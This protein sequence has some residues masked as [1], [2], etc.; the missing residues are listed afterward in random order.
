MQVFGRAVA[1]L[2][3]EAMARFDVVI[4]GG[5]IF[6]G[7][8]NP[9]YLSDIGIK[10]GVIAEIG[11]LPDSD[12][13]KVLD[14]GGMHV[15]PGFIDLHTHYDGQIFWDP[16]CSISGWHGTTSV[17]IGNCGF[18]LAPVMS[19]L[20]DRSML[21]LTRNEAIPLASMRAGIPWDWET[22]PEYL[23]SVDR[24]PKSVNVLPYVGLTPLL[25]WVMGMDRAK[26]G[27]LPT[28]AEHQ[29]MRRLLHEAMDAGACGWSVQRMSTE[30]NFQRDFDGTPLPT[31]VMHDET[32]L[33]L[34][35]V[36]GE[37]NAGFMQMTL[38]RS[39]TD[40]TADRAHTEQ[41]A[42][43]SRRPVIWNAVS[44]FA[45]APVHR[46]VIGWLTS[47]RERGLR[48]YGQAATTEAPLF[49]TFEDWNLWDDSPAWREA[50][51]GTTEE[52]LAKL[53]DPVRREAMRTTPT[54]AGSSGP[55]EDIVLLRTSVAEHKQ[56]ENLKISDICVLA[57]KDAI[58]A[59][60]DIAVADGLKALF[61]TEPFNG[62]RAYQ[63][64]V[65]EFEYGIAGVSDGGAHTK[66]LT[67]GRYPTEYLIKWV[68]DLAWISLEDAHWRLSAYPAFCAGFTN[69]G[70]IKVG[71]PA[72]II[73]YDFA[74]L[75]VQPPEIV[76][77]FPADEWR[78]V[79][80]AKGY[81]Y[82]LVNG[83]VTIE[84]DKET[85]VSSGRLLRHGV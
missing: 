42:A 26:A 64:E 28:D 71:A 20:R 1:E 77:D 47:C 73:V 63:R 8:R 59:I 38:S 7:A 40:P 79:Q 82:V 69:R 13:T 56:Y 37:R 25:I 76:F 57:G 46:D 49:F 85:G 34:A 21:A 43:I 18:G 75:E 78:R 41:L 36:L 10:D 52:R 23:E 70:V 66:F 55:I 44:A 74:N 81:R 68:R 3:G 61:Y 16:Y 67:A 72:D 29:E 58:D 62:P 33:Q 51:L 14:A 31:D 48:V 11:L 84:D 12:A 65:V 6:D 19:E 5:M 50:T 30:I 35:E 4:K 17:V 24:T 9:R 2:G 60:L 53:A 83:Q 32:A 80:R 15:A 22:Y 27:E 54:L 45:A 39:A